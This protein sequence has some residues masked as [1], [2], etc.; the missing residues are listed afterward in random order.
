MNFINYYILRKRYT[1][2]D[3][4]NPKAILTEQDRHAVKVLIVDDEEFIY[5]DSLR[6][7]GFMQ[8]TRMRLKKSM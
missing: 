5:V 6:R 8:S 1:I 7:A 3:L 4:V 2:S